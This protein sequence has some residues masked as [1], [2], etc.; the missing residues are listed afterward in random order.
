MR[1][2][3]AGSSGLIGTAL[4]PALEASG[5]EVV[6]LVRRKARGTDESEWHP[7]A[8]LIDADLVK[9]ADLVVNL[10]GAS[11]GERRLTDAYAKIVLDSRL[12]TTGLLARTMAEAGRG[13]L[14]QASAMGYFGVRGEAELHERSHP[15]SGT[16]PEITIAWERAANPAML[17]G[18]SVQ[19]LRTGLVIAPTGGLAKRLLPLIRLGLVRSLGS[20]KQWMSWIS[21]D[22]AVRAIVFLAA[23][24]HVGPVNLVA[25]LP[26]RNAE[27]IAALARAA[28]RPRLFPVPAPMLRLVV[29]PAADDLLGSQ[30]AL[31]GVLRRLGFR[32]NHPDI[33]G[34]ANWVLGVTHDG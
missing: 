33:Q 7:E 16:L 13:R 11:I 29:G 34:A 17:A 30:K 12:E 3:V 20:G 5:Y 18:V 8:G 4:V 15:G 10:A 24:D 31:P 28:H 9:R 26:A 1:A 25:P 6:R 19:W 23:S 14:I 21:L 22:D 32:W 27:L 2:V